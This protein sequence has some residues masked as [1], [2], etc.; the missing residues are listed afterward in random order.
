[1]YALLK[2]H[3]SMCA[4]R[5]K[6][7]NFF[8]RAVDWRSEIDYYHSL[9]SPDAG[10]ILFEASPSYTSP[11]V[12]TEKICDALYAYNPSLKFIYMVRNPLDRI[13]SAYCQG[14][15][16]R[17]I[18]VS[19]HEALTQ[20]PKYIQASCYYTRI[21]PFINRFGT[22]HVLI[23]DF[24][25][26]ISRSPAMFQMVAGF[27]GIDAG[28]LAN[29]GPVHV[30]KSLS[31]RQY[32]P[33]W[34]HGWR[35]GIRM[36]SPHIWQKLAKTTPRPF[37]EI[38]KLSVTDQEMILMK[39]GDDIDRLENLLGKSLAHWKTVHDRSVQ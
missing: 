27:I 18:H 28:L 39:I 16:Q 36:I 13:V 25:D 21:S 30:N 19:L 4:S 9:F 2:R 34:E 32:N 8:S 33:K 1:M 38:P 7:T 35:K 31:N 24:D 12:N 22:D 26:F 10:Q 6:E 17:R 11:R 20:E 29:I 3:P 5:I 14:F 23:L 37:P 15:Q